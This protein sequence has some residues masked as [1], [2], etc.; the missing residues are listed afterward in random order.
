MIYVFW[1]Q[2][3][4]RE[5]ERENRPGNEHEQISAKYY[6]YIY[7]KNGEGHANNLHNRNKIKM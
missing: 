5:V 2:K 7:Y 1:Q 3:E 4:E 6:T